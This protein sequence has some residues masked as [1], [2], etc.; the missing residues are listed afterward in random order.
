MNLLLP[1]WFNQHRFSSAALSPLI[2]FDIHNQTAFSCSN[3]VH[4]HYWLSKASFSQ[5]C[6]QQQQQQI[7]NVRFV[8]FFSFFAPH[9]CNFH[10]ICHPAKNS[11]PH[12]V[13]RSFGLI[14]SL[15]RI[16]GQW[17]WNKTWPFKIPVLWDTLASV[18]SVVSGTHIFAD[19]RRIRSATQKQFIQT[20]QPISCCLNTWLNC[21]WAQI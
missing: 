6:D 1:Q 8:L 13:Q 11:K 16:I 12:T 19:G 5:P 7:L 15:G 21:N 14:L 4:I 18:T 20:K 17:S 3:N 2:Y 10:P 9:I